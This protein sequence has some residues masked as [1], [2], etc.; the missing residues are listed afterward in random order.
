MYAKKSL[1]QHF[2]TSESAVDVIIDAGDVTADDIILE[3][4]PGKGMLTKKLLF[5]ARKIIAVEKDAQ[6]VETLKE[7]FK[8]EIKNKKLIL[9]H[10]DILDY[11]LQ[12]KN[13]KLIANIPYNITGVLIRK[14][15]ETKHQPEIMVLMLQKEVVERIVAKNKKP[16][17][18]AHGKE[19]ILSISVKAYGEPKYVQMV[20]A[21]SFSPAPKVD[22]AILLI[23]NISKKF[24]KD[25]PEKEFFGILHAGFKSKRKKLSSNLSVV[26][27]KEKVLEVFK[28]LNFDPNLRAEDLSLEGWRKLSEGLF[29]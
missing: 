18:S 1:G 23:Q 8:K 20:K 16:F 9:V 7:K 29:Y 3:V 10:D 4:G 11:K 19:S 26:I 17:D 14:F 12:I 15:L 5:F 27:K 13:Y 22:S 2:L 25:F 21:G 28:K 6:L 24:F